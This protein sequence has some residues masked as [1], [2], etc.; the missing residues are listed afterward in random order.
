MQVLD[1]G[2]TLD[3]MAWCCHYT[4]V[5]N[6]DDKEGLCPFVYPCR[7]RLECYIIF[8]CEPLNAIH[9]I[10]HFLTG[11]PEARLHHHALRP[12]IPKGWLVLWF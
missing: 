2:S 9:L 8:V 3:N 10:C 11:L 6:S 4:F 1:S 7:V 12:P 5:V